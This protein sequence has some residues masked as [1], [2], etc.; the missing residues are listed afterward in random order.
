MKFFTVGQIRSRKVFLNLTAD[1]AELR[2]LAKDK[3][4]PRAQHHALAASRWV[5]KAKKLMIRELET[6]FKLQRSAGEL[7]GAL[8]FAAQAVAERD[9]GAPSSQIS[10][11]SAP[12]DSMPPSQDMPDIPG[13]YGPGEP[14]PGE[15]GP[16]EPGRGE[17]GPGETGPGETPKIAGQFE[18][19]TPEKLSA[20][21]AVWHSAPP[22]GGEYPPRKRPRV[23]KPRA[24]P[25]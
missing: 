8:T 19:D 10:L 11:P 2:R 1:M 23:D 9:E 24:S 22:E 13:E 5:N 18:T 20:A 17:P 3:G 14:G 4:S 12:G 6:R 16:G 21:C 7:R 25:P 15:P